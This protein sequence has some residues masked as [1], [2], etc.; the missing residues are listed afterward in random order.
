MAA[1][2]AGEPVGAAGGNGDGAVLDADPIDGGGVRQ[3][4]SFLIGGVP[5]EV[6]IGVVGLG[7]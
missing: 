7:I 6:L 5:G 2:L 4:N 1:V 3:V